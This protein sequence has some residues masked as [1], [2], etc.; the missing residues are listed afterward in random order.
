MQRI[1]STILAGCLAS[2]FAGAVV[3][4]E[5]GD[6]AAPYKGL[7]WRNIGP[8]FMSGRIGDIARHPTD[9]S[10]WYVGVASGGVWKTSTAGVTFT[11]VFDDETAYS[12]GSI[13]I[14]PSNPHTVWVGT[15]ENNGGRH[16]GFGDGIYRSDDGGDNWTNMG[17]KES[18]HI[19]TIIVHPTDSNTVWAAVQG[20]LWT[21][22]GERG[23]YMTTDGGKNWEKTLGG[24]EW[25]G[26]TDVVIDARDPNILYAATWQHQRTV[27]AYIGGGP[28]SGLHR[29]LDGGK[30]WTRLNQ[31]LPTGNMG[32]IGLAISLQNPD[33]V[34]AAIELDRRTGGVWRSEDRGASWVK[35]ADAVSGGTGPHYYQE[36]TASMHQHDRLYLVGPTVLKSEDGGK[37]FEPMPHPNQHGD[38]HAVVFD[39]QDPDYI[40]MGTDGGVYE[41][42]DL[43]GT[44]RYMSNLPVTQF[45]KLA[46]DDS[47]PFY[48]IYGGTQDNN[49]QGGPSRTDS[50]NGIRNADWKVVLG[51]D[52]HQPATEPGNPDIVYAE[53][54]QGHL[55]RVDMTTGEH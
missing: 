11:P 42:F 53:S 50:V 22:G 16:I 38:M 1:L 32:K 20:P 31:G 29:S 33:V 23:L 37:T 30:T 14:D 47:E 55:N 9:S 15:G 26:V 13:A 4:A 40:M 12:I 28:E 36:L 39:P 17:L 7:E 46:L 54:Q 44:W 10:T 6:T 3:G 41:S 35:G 49:T 27:A 24:G 34:Y 45:Y 19:S 51:G 5:Q 2:C 43:G 8:G 21:K 48:N 18:Q 52:G 25:T